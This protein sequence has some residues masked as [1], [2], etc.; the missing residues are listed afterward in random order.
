LSYFM[1]DNCHR[2]LSSGNCHGSV[3]FWKS[4]TSPVPEGSGEEAAGGGEEVAPGESQEKA[5]SEH[6]ALLAVRASAASPDR[7]FSLPG[8]AARPMVGHRP[9]Q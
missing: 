8:K 1:I 3:R 6:S 7:A 4:L 2:K 9:R 5:V